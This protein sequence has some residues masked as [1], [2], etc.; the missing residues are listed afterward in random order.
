M[1]SSTEA[2]LRRQQCFSNDWPLFFLT[3]GIKHTVP[4]STEYLFLWGFVYWDHPFN[5]FEELGLLMASWP[6]LHDPPVHVDL[7]PS[8]NQMSAA[9][10]GWY[11][12]IL[13]SSLHCT[14]LSPGSLTLLLSC[15]GL[16]VCSLASLPPNIVKTTGGYNTTTHQTTPLSPRMLHSMIKAAEKSLSTSILYLHHSLSRY[17]AQV[18]VHKETNLWLYYMYTTNDHYK[19]ASFIQVERNYD[20]WSAIQYS[21]R[22]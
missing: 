11:N 3:S 19:D 7:I 9:R 16:I 12:I 10:D 20:F 14:V 22:Q 15:L 4:P 1:C 5:A 18:H 13:L 2:R 6:V 17:F 21:R 8:E